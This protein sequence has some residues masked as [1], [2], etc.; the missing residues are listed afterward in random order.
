MTSTAPKQGVQLK[1]TQTLSVTPQM[2]QSLKVLQ[3]NQLELEQEISRMLDENI[4]LERP[5]GEDFQYDSLSADE[6]E[7]FDDVSADALGDEIPEH[8]D[9][10]I[11]WEDLYDDREDYD[12]GSHHEDTEGFQD[13]WVADS[14][15]FDEQLEQAIH[16][17]PLNSEEKRLATA[18]L[19]HLDE[20]YF[21]TIA[22]DKLA[23]KLKTDL[24][25]LQG[26]IDIIKHLDPPGIACQDIRECMLAQLHSLPEFTDT[27]GDAHDILSEYFTYIGQKESL[28]RQRLHLS[29]TAFDNAMRLIRSLSPYPNTSGETVS[30]SIRADVFVRERM[31]IF[32]ASTNQDARHDIGIN[33]DYAA[34]TQLCKG[35]EKRF[36][37]AQL[38]AAKFFLRA[39]DQRRQTILRVTNAI[40]MQQQEYFVS[41]DKALRPLLM[42]E[43]A[44]QLEL[45]EST[46]SRAVNGKYLSFEHRLIE[47]RTFFSSDLSGDGSGEADGEVA[48]SAAAVKAL[49][50]ELIAD[51]P[52]KK[53]LSDSRLEKILQEKGIDIA[54]R[55]I[56]K[57][58][59]SM[60][61]P[62]TSKRKRRN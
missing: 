13:N 58:R 59:E 53:P 47:L 22:H 50:K 45:A 8:I 60:G 43:I 54:R 38:Q 31:G 6:G 37:S 41:G 57:Y 48:A 34:M 11:E 3:C 2:Q 24:E 39:L 4:M 26:V 35:D 29:Q 21:L 27:V 10:D 61:I 46:I 23:K 16:L 42:R 56:A 18:V 28:I 51:E 55:T 33:E 25:T 32:Y 62:A 14:E 7:T 44:E 9:S 5:D 30:G 1:Q 49:I 20:R 40:V 15:S 19:A 52:P 12:N 36:M 17:A